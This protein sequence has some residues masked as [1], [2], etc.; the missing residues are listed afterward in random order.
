MV[1]PSAALVAAESGAPVGVAAGRTGAFPPAGVLLRVADLVAGTVFSAVFAVTGDFFAGAACF[2]G[3]AFA[4]PVVFFAAAGLT[5]FTVPIA[6]VAAFAAG[7]DFVAVA[8]AGTAFAAVAFVAGAAFFVGVAFAA[9]AAFFA[10]SAFF[11]VVFAAAGAAFVRARAWGVSAVAGTP[12]LVAF[13]TA[14]ARSAMAVP[15]MQKRARGGAPRTPEAGKDTEPVGF[16]QTC[17]T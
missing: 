14:P 7:V 13:R 4:A 2:A 8:L 3:A 9:D 11:A 16:R 15:H 10:G 12:D 6:F 1:A 5:A 17:H